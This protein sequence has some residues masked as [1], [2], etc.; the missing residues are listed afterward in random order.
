MGA[1]DVSGAGS[2]GGGGSDDGR[3]G[4]VDGLRGGRGL[5]REM[6]MKSL[7]GWRTKERRVK[8]PGVRLQ[9]PT[10]YWYHSPSAENRKKMY[11]NFHNNYQDCDLQGCN[12]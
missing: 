12:V 3:G 9:L 4:A 7:K 6:M 2:A 5:E 1:E 8:S 11:F 10:L